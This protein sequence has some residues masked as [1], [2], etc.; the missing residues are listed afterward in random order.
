[1]CIQIS[2]KRRALAEDRALAPGDTSV[3]LVVPLACGHLS[4]HIRGTAEV[5]RQLTSA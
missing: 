5:A 1:M 4:S 2:D 3:H